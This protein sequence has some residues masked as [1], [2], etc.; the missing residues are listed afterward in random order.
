MRDDH[1]TA[2]N[3]AGQF[4]ALSQGEDTLGWQET[5]N[6]QSA[7]IKKD[8]RLATVDIE[9]LPPC[10]GLL[11]INTWSEDQQTCLLPDGRHL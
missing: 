6:K 8:W 5:F 1:I 4:A 2:R 7:L 9:E 10:Y 11:G 3:I